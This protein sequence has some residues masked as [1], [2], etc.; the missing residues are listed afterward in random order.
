MTDTVKKALFPLGKVVVTVGAQDAFAKAYSTQAIE[1][2]HILIS[3]HVSG[4]W[5][6][7][8]K[9]DAKQN[10]RSVKARGDGRSMILSSYKLVDDTK[11]WIITEWDRSVTTIL[12][13][14]EY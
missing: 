11:V 7:I 10:D 5:G 8:D 14:S 3:R 2:A 12:L 1:A 9:D 13:P 4:D 6:D